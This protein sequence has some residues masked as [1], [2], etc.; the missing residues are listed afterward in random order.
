MFLGVWGFSVYP[1]FSF[2]A[3]RQG[4]GE[5]RVNCLEGCGG[6]GVARGAVG[7]GVGVVGSGS[8]VDGW[9]LLLGFFFI[10]SY[11]FFN[12]SYKT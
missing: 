5:S 10:G 7:C 4:W 12:N 1:G 11:F 8:G 3:V 2:R 9:V 6:W